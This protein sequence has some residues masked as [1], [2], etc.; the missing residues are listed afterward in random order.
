MAHQTRL[1]GFKLLNDVVWISLVEPDGDRGFPAE[2]CHLLAGERINFLFLTCGNRESV[3]G[4]DI[5]ADPDNASKALKLIKGNFA[6]TNHETMKGSVLSLFPHKS[7][8][9]ITAALL[10]VF[11]REGIEPNALAYSNSAISAVLR[12]S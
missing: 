8:P 11:G 7:D 9:E 4:L 6:K 10:N 3:W 5:V 1:G 2:F 12:F